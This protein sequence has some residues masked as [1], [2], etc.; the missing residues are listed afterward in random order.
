MSVTETVVCRRQA[1]SAGPEPADVRIARASM[2]VVRPDPG[3][4]HQTGVESAVWLDHVV[5]ARRHDPAALGRLVAEYERYARSLAARM[6]RHGEPRADLDQVALEALVVAL[7][8]FEPTRGLPFV[9]YATPTI[10][11]ALRRHYRD[12]GWLLRVPRVVHELTVG[13]HAVGE[14]LTVE[15]GRTPTVTEIAEAMDV[16]VDDL[17]AA[18]EAVYA[19]DAQS[20]DAP[21]PGGG[22]MAARFGMVDT[23]LALAED[24]VALLAAMADIDPGS[25]ELLRLYFFDECTQ[26]EI[27]GRL[28]ISQMQVS[29]RIAAVLRT[30]RAQMECV[31]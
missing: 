19:R 16:P 26:T 23:E 14:R 13:S 31:D 22:S 15:L 27:G 18:Q 4:R 24:R 6:Q 28:G 17:L 11:G 5:F 10:L 29:R 30:L 7:H 1:R 9:S 2:P 8:R 20:L 25:H 12:R 3:H 21:A